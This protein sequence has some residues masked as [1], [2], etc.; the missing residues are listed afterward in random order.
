MA[1]EDWPCENCIVKACCNKSILFSGCDKIRVHFSKLV[2][3]KPAYKGGVS[4]F[5]PRKDMV[6]NSRKEKRSI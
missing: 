3:Q 2:F 4:S 6:Q 1:V 5:D